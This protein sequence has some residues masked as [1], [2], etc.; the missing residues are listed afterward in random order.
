MIN[1]NN[2]NPKRGVNKLQDEISHILGK[3]WFEWVNRAGCSGWSKS[4]IRDNTST[5]KITVAIS[6]DESKCILKIHSFDYDRFKPWNTEY[7]GFCDSIEEFHN[8]MKRL[9]RDSLIQK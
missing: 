1:L 7:M 8:I 3:N 6:Y 2:M 9:N 4:I 5:K